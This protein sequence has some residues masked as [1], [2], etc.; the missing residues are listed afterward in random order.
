MRAT[1]LIMLTCL[2]SVTAHAQTRERP[3]SMF[4]RADANADGSL[5]RE[6][7][8]A[9]RADQFATRDRNSDGAFDKADIGERAADRPRVTQAMSAMLSQF[10]ADRDGKVSKAEFVDGGLKLFDRADANKNGTLD[11]KEREEAE[12][13]MREKLGR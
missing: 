3:G 13:S 2:L 7:F 5:T 9:A 11:Q 1:S 6:E 8:A 12:S 4:D 10:D